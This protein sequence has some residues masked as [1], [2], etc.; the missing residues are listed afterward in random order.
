[1]DFIKYDEDAMDMIPINTIIGSLDKMGK[2]DFDEHEV[3][4][5]CWLEPLLMYWLCIDDW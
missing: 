1:M 3:S 2:Y 4:S 5:H